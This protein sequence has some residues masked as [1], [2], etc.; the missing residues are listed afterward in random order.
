MKKS[1]DTYIQSIAHDNEQYIIDGGY[2]SL[3]DYIISNAEN[4][5]GYYEFFDS[6]E[7]DENNGEPTEEQIDELKDYLNDN[8]NLCCEIN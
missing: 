1:I 4:G 7:L 8:Y 2:D 3:A 6:D 5:S